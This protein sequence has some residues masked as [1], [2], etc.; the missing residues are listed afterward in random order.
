[1]LFVLRDLKRVEGEKIPMMKD[2]SG[3]LSCSEG[4]NDGWVEIDRRGGRE[5][6]KTGATPMRNG[7]CSYPLI[8]RRSCFHRKAISLEDQASEAQ[9]AYGVIF[10]DSPP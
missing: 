10:A 6:P 9:K 7:S 3:K 5:K 2:S 1:M 4:R 8:V